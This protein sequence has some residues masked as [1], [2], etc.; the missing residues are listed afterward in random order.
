MMHTKH[1]ILGS[2]VAAALLMGVSLVSAEESA[3]AT[4]EAAHSTADVTSETIVHSDETSVEG[5]VDA[6]VTDTPA[7]DGVIEY[8]SADDAAEHDSHEQDTGVLAP[9]P[10]K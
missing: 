9:V 8:T 2:F 7:T 10:V 1:I 4:S 3:V 5:S 6:V